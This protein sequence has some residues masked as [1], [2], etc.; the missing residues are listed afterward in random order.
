M[1]LVKTVLEVI[2]VLLL[3]QG[4]LNL[5]VLI[6]R[7]R[8]KEVVE[9]EVAVKDVGVW[10][11]L[12]G[13]VVALEAN[14][15]RTHNPAL[16]LCN[17]FDLVAI[18]GN[19]HVAD[20]VILVEAE[21]EGSSRHLRSVL[22]DV[23]PASCD[24]FHV[25]ILEQFLGRIMGSDVL[26]GVVKLPFRLA[27]KNIFRA[28]GPQGLQLNQFVMCL[29]LRISLDDRQKLKQRKVDVAPFAQPGFVSLL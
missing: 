6:L 15:S 20:V 2:F 12:D 19:F 28:L 22:G 8:V 1:Q 29:Q 24:F 3:L 23:L 21:A 17:C 5:E 4:N 25:N 10:F 13:G 27:D 18:V 14:A 26:V 9:V 16:L 7:Q 11:F